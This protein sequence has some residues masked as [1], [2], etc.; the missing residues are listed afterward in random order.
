MGA[1]CGQ[2]DV[3]VR[4]PAA[5]LLLVLNRRWSPARLEVL[6][7]AAVFD[8]GWRTASPNHQTGS[9]LR[10]TMLATASGFAGPGRRRRQKVQSVHDAHPSG[11]PRRA[12][13]GLVGMR[14]RRLRRRCRT[15]SHRDGS[16]IIVAGTMGDNRRHLAAQAEPREW[17]RTPGCPT[18]GIVPDRRLTAGSMA[19]HQRSHHRSRRW[20]PSGVRWPP[21]ADLDGRQH[22]R[23]DGRLPRLIPRSRG[24]PG[25]SSK[26]RVSAGQARDREHLTHAVVKPIRAERRRQPPGGSASAR[27]GNAP[28][29][30]HG[31]GAIATIRSRCRRTCG[32]DADVC[33][34]GWGTPTSLAKN[35]VARKVAMCGGSSL[36]GRQ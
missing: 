24:R 26:R 14:R 1:R 32:L 6:G 28:A 16:A 11:S 30:G 20:P 23:P 10:E 25:P 3:A 5:D 22:S 21:R 12:R 27:R 34:R 33:V 15:R 19:H 36:S 17:H 2:S 4:G 7:D 8:T 18:A 13:N 35:V 9:V 29:L 31:G